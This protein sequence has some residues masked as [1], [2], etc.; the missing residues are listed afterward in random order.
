M[1]VTSL[2]LSGFR[3]FVDMAP[4]NLDQINVLIGANNSGK[5]S[6]LRALYLLQQTDW[7]V[8]PDVR[9]G[10]D[11][12]TVKVG[13]EQASTPAWGDLG[14]GMA[15]I[16]LTS[17]DRSSGSHAIQFANE[18][19]NRNLN[20]LLP[21]EPNHFIVP[22]LSKRKTTVFHE[23]VR[24]QFVVEV[25]SSMANLAAKLSRLT[26]PS[27]PDTVWY[28]KTCEEILGFMV[29]ATPSANGQRAGIYLPDR[30]IMPIDQMGE[31]VPNIAALLV[32]LALSEGKLFLIEEPEN[33]LHPKALKALLDL[34]VESSESNQFVISTHSNIVL[35]HLGAAPS[36]QVFE[37]SAVPEKSPTEATIR[38]IEP[39]P[40]ARLEVLRSL[41]YSLAD[42]DL[43]EGWLFLEESSAERIIRDYLIP[44]FAPKLSRVRTLACNGTGQVEPTFKDF[45][46]LALFSHLE[47]IYEGATWVR[48]DGDASGLQVVEALQKGFPSWKPDRFKC[49]NRSSFEHYYPL[50]F[51]PQ[52][53]R[54]LAIENKEERRNQKKQLLMEVLD[55]LDEDETRGK[56]ALS[57]SA[58]EIIADLQ[59]IQAQLMSKES[60]AEKFKRVMPTH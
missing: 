14:T 28:K 15:T 30:T 53:E 6:V 57:E 46:R 56:A 50:L 22:F 21:E 9:V 43:W 52:A 25:R 41:G 31:G 16:T 18:H 24:H 40:Q 47:P 3:S 54:V 51:K 42:F 58:Q 20:I 7:S 4:I 27:F 2:Q 10:G 34:I 11:T 38:K 13:L 45:H 33:D 32:H 8:Y 19:G 55:W 17:T 12:A 26:N 35:R 59:C 23:D 36:S 60:A 37:V 48:A 1:R 39:T 44:W 49:F 5:S 29:T